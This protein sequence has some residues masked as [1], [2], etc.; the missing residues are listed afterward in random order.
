MCLHI[1]AKIVKRR[2][3]ARAQRKAQEAAARAA[4]EEIEDEEE[5]DAELDAQSFFFPSVCHT[6]VCHSKVARLSHCMSLQRLLL[7]FVVRCKCVVTVVAVTPSCLWKP[8]AE[9]ALRRDRRTGG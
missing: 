3:V 1:F 8:M 4:G 7:C 5:D 9:G 6:L 2:K